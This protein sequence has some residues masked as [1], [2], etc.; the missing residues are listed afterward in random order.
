MPRLFNLSDK[1]WIEVMQAERQTRGTDFTHAVI[2][3]EVLLE[4][5]TMPYNS[6]D[7]GNDPNLWIDFVSDGPGIN[8]T[9]KNLEKDAFDVTY[10]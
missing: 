7:W 5:F 9:T 2:I 10:W 6:P 4:G 3:G 1:V 8:P